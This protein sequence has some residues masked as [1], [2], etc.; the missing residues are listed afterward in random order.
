IKISGCP[1]S[2]GQHHLANIGFYGGALPVNGHTVPAFQMILGGNFGREMKLGT[3]I[4]QIP[5]KNVPEAV[6]SLVKNYVKNRQAGETFN[7]YYHRFGKEAV[8]R[9]LDNFLKI[10]SH[11]ERPDFYVDWEDKKEFSL[12][13]GVIGE[14]AGQMIDD[15]PPHIK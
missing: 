9:L 15:V 2:C 10:P 6:V 14:C 12:Q 4:C 1:N 13:K 11:E 3:M 7:A 8:V 5:S